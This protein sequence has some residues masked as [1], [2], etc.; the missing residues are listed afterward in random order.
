M[1][2]NKNAPTQ[3]KIPRGPYSI[4][5]GLADSDILSDPETRAFAQAV[6]KIQDPEKLACLAWLVQELSKKS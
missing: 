3:S 6:E 5:K 1:P 2:R 4:K